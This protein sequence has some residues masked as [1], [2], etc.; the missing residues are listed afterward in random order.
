MTKLPKKISEN[1]KNVSFFREVAPYIHSHREKTFVVAFAGEVITDQQFSQIIQDLA[2]ISGFGARLVLVHG[3]RPQIDERLKENNT[4]IHIHKG[5]RIT[6]HHAMIAA[7]EAIG[8]LRIR[9]ENMLTYTLNQPSVSSKGLGIISGNFITAR[10]MGIH[11]GIDYGFTGLI[12]K[13]NYPLI[14]QQLQAH[15]IVLLS[16]IGY[17]PTGEAYNLRYEHVAIAAAK[18]LTADKLIFLSHQSLDLPSILSLEQAKNYDY[19]LIPSVIEAL[20][21]GVDRIHL[22]D[23]KSDGVLLQELYTEE[24]VGTMIYTEKFESLRSATIDDINGILNLIHPLENKGILVKRSHQD[25]ERE[26]NNFHVITRD[27]KIIA[28]AALY[29]TDDEQIGELA[30]LAVDQKYRGGKRGD[31]LLGYI[32]KLAH[33]QGK[34]KLLVLTTQ[35]TDWFRE[36]GFFKGNVE[37]LPSNKK[38]LYNYKR[39]SQV[40]FKEIYQISTI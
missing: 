20:E 21:A 26:I 7:Q 1:I 35:T 14:Q 31:K 6:D 4:P 10:P 12:R 19:E 13:I 17:S 9:I 15:N 18:A 40:L 11:D 25:L 8:F 30:C 23:A 33:N 5:I 27:Q 39:N 24:G 29:D 38:S 22:L 2:I 37:D 28:C 16:P 32:T 36:R 34:T 3:T